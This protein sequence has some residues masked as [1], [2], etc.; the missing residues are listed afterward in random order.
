MATVSVNSDLIKRLVMDNGGVGKVSEDLGF[1]KTW[2][3]KVIDTGRV[4]APG[5]KA[6]A[7][8]FG[9]DESKIIVP[10]AVPQFKNSKASKSNV[11]IDTSKFKAF[12][13]AHGTYESFAES[14]GYKKSWVS[15]VLNT[16]SIKLSALRVIC[17]TYGVE[18]GY[19]LIKEE[20]AEPETVQEETEFVKVEE[21]APK[22]DDNTALVI[23]TALQ[24]LELIVEKLDYLLS[25]TSRVAGAV[26]NLNNN[27]VEL[28]QAM[29]K[30]I[31]AN[32]DI[33]N[34]TL[35]KIH[36]T[37]EGIKCSIKKGAK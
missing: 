28:M 19:F 1:H 35:G 26:T 25:A 33:L 6:L 10:D 3:F 36:N 20:P 13:N 15:Y 4:T 29:R 31:N 21:P 8:Y 11:E 23:A 2:L 18:E 16:G 37:T 24:R 27:Q 30:N 32:T 34:E 14:I 5:A 9:M 22:Q 7:A 17:K 12:V